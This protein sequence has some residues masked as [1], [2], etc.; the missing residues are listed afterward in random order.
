MHR[1]PPADG[2]RMW[3]VCPDAVYLAGPWG[4]AGSRGHDPHDTVW[5]GRPIHNEEQGTRRGPERTEHESGV[6]GEERGKRLAG[7]HSLRRSIRP[8]VTVRSFPPG[9]PRRRIHQFSSECLCM[10][11]RQHPTSL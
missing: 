1:T 5:L 11:M 6:T 8:R 9:R 10:E 3:V 4:T 7:D 2:R